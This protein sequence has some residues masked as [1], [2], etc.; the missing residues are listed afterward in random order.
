MTT[1]REFAA[2]QRAK[3]RRRAPRSS[4]GAAT[5]TRGPVEAISAR[6]ILLA[7]AQPVGPRA[8]R[9][10]SSVP[11]P[12]GLKAHASDFRLLTSDFLLPIPGLLAT[13]TLPE[14]ETFAGIKTAAGA[15]DALLAGLRLELP[16]L[17]DQSQP[18]AEGPRP[19][20]SEE[21]EANPPLSLTG[22]GLR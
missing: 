18:V 1:L 20:A 12:L 7:P 4:T 10:A 2:R 6:E 8:P 21:R 9:E 3:A 15:L 14:P 16:A 19:P 17:H 5:N 13:A 22:R 11:P